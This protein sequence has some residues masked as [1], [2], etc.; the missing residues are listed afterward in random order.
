MAAPRG[1]PQPQHQHVGAAANRIASRT[2]RNDRL[3]DGRILGRPAEAG[4]LLKPL[5]R[6]E[7]CLQCAPGS[8]GIVDAKEF[9]D[10]LDVR[11][12][13]LRKMDHSMRRAFGGG[14]S[15]AVPQLSIQAL[16]SCNGMPKRV[17]SNSRRRRRSSSISGPSMS[18][19][20][21]EQRNGF[22]KHRGDLLTTFCGDLAQTLVSRSVD[23][24]GAADE[25]HGWKVGLAGGFVETAPTNALSCRACGGVKKRPAWVANARPNAFAAASMGSLHSAQPTLAA[26]AGQRETSHR[27][28]DSARLIRMLVVSGIVI[29]VDWPWM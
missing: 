11:A 28:S 6:S 18:T 1:I 7:D 27:T 14:N 29:E 17:R 19:N 20:R 26:L 10:P 4:K 22:G 13:F 3:T 5:K 21:V 8:V 2:L 25:S 9:A 16:T 12:G 24:D 15:F 23:V